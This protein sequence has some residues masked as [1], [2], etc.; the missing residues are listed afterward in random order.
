MLCGTQG[1]C[2]VGLKVNVVWDSRLRGTA[3]Q[4][5]SSNNPLR[6]QGS[7]DEFLTNVSGW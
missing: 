7:N 6:Q 2:C 4:N 5:V 1:E 3:D